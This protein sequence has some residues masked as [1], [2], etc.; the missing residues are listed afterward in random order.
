MIREDMINALLRAETEAREVLQDLNT[1][2]ETCGGCRL[3]KY[4]SKDEAIWAKPLEGA[5]N[6]LERIRREMEGRVREG[7]KEES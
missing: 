5:I 4:V 1:E 3:E 7:L 6:R 2:T